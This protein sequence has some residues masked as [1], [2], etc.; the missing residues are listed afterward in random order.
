MTSWP[1][2]AMDVKMEPPNFDRN[3]S[4]PGLWF[5]GDWSSGIAAKTR[6]KLLRIFLPK[7]RIRLSGI[8]STGPGSLTP[9]PTGRWS[10]VSTTG[11]DLCERT[12][13]LMVV[14]ARNN[15]LSHQAGRRFGS[16]SIPPG[17]S[18]KVG[19]KSQ[20]GTVQSESTPCCSWALTNSSASLK[21]FQSPSRMQC[22]TLPSQTWSVSSRQFK[23]PAKTAMSLLKHLGLLQDLLE[24]VHALVELA[25]VGGPAFFF[26]LVS[27]C[28][29]YLSDAIETTEDFVRPP[30]RHRRV[31]SLCLVGPPPRR[32]SSILAAR[33][34]VRDQGTPA[35][36]KC[37][38]IAV[39]V[40]A[41]PSFSTTK[42][43]T[44]ALVAHDAGAQVP[45]DD[46][47]ADAR[48]LVPF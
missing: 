16:Y 30:P 32:R 5:L 13:V 26:R 27:V 31:A 10:D 35:T 18:L 38:L 1:W 43:D 39:H 2:P 33:T 46:E 25:L 48:D 3:V 44:T 24:G 34:R 11:K 36:Y 23:S 7:L 40:V 17:L 8:F 45:V 22:S 19:A 29:V 21:L 41:K 37:A 14:S 12:T 15:T 28:V 20:T 4:R 6:P 42:V 9:G 47:A